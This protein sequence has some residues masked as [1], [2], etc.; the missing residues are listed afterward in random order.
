MVCDFVDGASVNIGNY[1]GKY[2]HELQ[3][4]YVKKYM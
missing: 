4:K 3:K 1:N 2:F